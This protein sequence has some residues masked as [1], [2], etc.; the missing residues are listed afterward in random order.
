[1]NYL[2]AP[3]FKEIFPEFEELL[4]REYTNIADMNIAVNMWISKGFGFKV[5]YIRSSEMTVDAVNEE[6]VIKICKMLG[7]DEYI[8]GN[9]A[10][11]YQKDVHFEDAGVKLTYT[12]YEP[13][14]Y[15]QL[16]GEF[17]KNMSVLDY[18]FNCGFDWERIENDLK[19]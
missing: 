12:D 16:W 15:P 14:E 7:G 1:M 10:R 8:S 9:G 5:E 18:I 6:R 17:I 19:R 11:A 4:N 3:H 13:V 2:R